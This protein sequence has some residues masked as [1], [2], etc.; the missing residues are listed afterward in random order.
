[1]RGNNP[2]TRANARHKVDITCLVLTSTIT[3]TEK[4]GIPPTSATRDVD[5]YYYYYYYYY[6]GTATNGENPDS[7]P[8]TIRPNAWTS[9]K[10]G[11]PATLNSTGWG[12]VLADVRPDTLPT[13]SR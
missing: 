3:W 13:A 11:L 7:Y 1:M 2:E 10:K 5:Y 4:E 6:H 8:P 9:G 12:L